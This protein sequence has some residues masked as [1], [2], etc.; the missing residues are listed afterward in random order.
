MAHQPRI[1]T[2]IT[3]FSQK[4]RKSWGRT[5]F[6]ILSS[7]QTLTMRQNISTAQCLFV[8]L[9][10]NIFLYCEVFVHGRYVFNLG[11]NYTSICETQIEAKR[12][13]FVG[14]NIF[15]NFFLLV[16]LEIQRKFRPY[17]PTVF[18]NHEVVK[19]I[20]FIFLS[21]ESHIYNS[22]D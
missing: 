10:T 19:Y 18:V 16:I 5:R 3:L 13:I 15:E 2:K 14:K 9:K 8:S 7:Q 6:T 11:K 21:F 1:S 17:V 12:I 4:L 22:S 20:K